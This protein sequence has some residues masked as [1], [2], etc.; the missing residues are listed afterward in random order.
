MGSS[1]WGCYYAIGAAFF[2]LT[3]LMPPWLVI[4]PLAFGLLWT[5][6][7]V[8]IGLHLRRVGREMAGSESHTSEIRP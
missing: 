3:L 1:Y 2:A 6:C 7:A 8:A 4:A 5:A